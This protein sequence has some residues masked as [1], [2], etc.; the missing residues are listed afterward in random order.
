M[1]RCLL[2]M[3]NEKKYLYF[4]ILKTKNLKF[5]KKCWR[6][7]LLLLGWVNCFKQFLKFV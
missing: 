5:D 6:Q 7:K 2:Y 3:Y 4:L 1:Y